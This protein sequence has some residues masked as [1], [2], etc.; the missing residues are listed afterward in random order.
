MQ[1]R[2]FVSI[3]G[4]LQHTRLQHCSGG[5][6]R[7]IY[8]GVRDALQQSGK[9]TP[10]ILQAIFNF[11]NNVTAVTNTNRVAGGWRQYCAGH[12]LIGDRSEAAAGD[13]RHPQHQGQMVP[14][15]TR[16]G[17]GAGQGTGGSDD[18]PHAGHQV[19]PWSDCQPAL[20][21]RASWLTAD[22]NKS[23]SAVVRWCLLVSAGVC[24]CL[25]V[26]AGAGQA[27]TPLPTSHR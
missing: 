18:C 8:P 14:C 1:P 4:L 25:L 27:D 7:V 26:S 2:H 15:V 19:S 5:V 21:M 24:W 23:V 12:W 10:A 20:Q 9:V 17:A 13:H 3:C 22:Q 16:G 6:T 11:V